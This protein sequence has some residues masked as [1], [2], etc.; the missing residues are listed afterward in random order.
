MTTRFSMHIEGCEVRYTRPSCPKDHVQ[1]CE[2]AWRNIPQEQWVHKFINT[3][4]TTPI[5]WYLQAELC[6]ITTDW[7]G[8]TQNFVTTFLFKSQYPSVDQA[9][10]IVRQK[11]FE[12]ASSLPLEQEEDEWT[13]PLQKLQGCYNIN[14]DEDDDSRK[15]NL[16]KTEGQ[17]DV[18]GPGV[19][20]P[21]IGQPIKIKKVNIRTEQTLKLANVRDYWDAATIDKITKLLHEYQ[22]L[23]LTKFT[24]MKGIKG[25]IGE[26]RIPLKPDARPVKQRPYILN[27]KYKEKV[28][29]ELD[30]MLE[31]GI[32]EP[33]EE[34][35]WISPMVV[36]DKKT[37]EI[38]ICVDIREVERCLFA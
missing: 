29:I 23:F 19:E 24:D 17:R 3:L 31:A 37:E 14:V 4:D 16:T 8:M 22:N 11:V 27:P 1:S 32:I 20:L 12:E 33:V 18:E 36:Q 34:S 28:K 2:E 21:F 30:K 7:E 25:P 15:V 35:E 6:L 10:K 5:N 38:R 13:A 26:M 9:L